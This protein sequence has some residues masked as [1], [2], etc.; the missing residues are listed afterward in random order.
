MQPTHSDLNAQPPADSILQEPHGLV[1]LIPAVVAAL[2]KTLFIL[3]VRRCNPSFPAYVPDS[4]SL[5]EA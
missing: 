4:R 2:K 3:D 5:R 1:A